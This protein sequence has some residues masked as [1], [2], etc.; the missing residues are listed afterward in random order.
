MVKTF[1]CCRKAY[2]YYLEKRKAAWETERKLLSGFDCMKD[3]TMLKKTK[4]FA[5]LCEVSAVCLQQSC[6]DLYRAY[7][8]FFREVKNGQMVGYLRFKSK[9]N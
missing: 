1:G 2:N 8:N 6:R 7:S 3:L 9:M 4:D 5:Y